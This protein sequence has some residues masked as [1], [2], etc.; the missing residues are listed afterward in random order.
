MKKYFIMIL[1]ALSIA[2]AVAC[3]ACSKGPKYYKLNYDEIDGIT[4]T[5]DIFNDADVKEGY[6][7]TFTV[8]I[9]WKRVALDD[10][11]KPYVVTANGVALTA[12]ENGYYSF[13]ISDNTVI[14][15]EGVY[16]LTS[17]L[18]TFDKGNPRN[19]T[20][21]S[22]DGDVEKGITALAG[23]EITFRVNKSSYYVGDYQVC[24]NTRELDPQADGSYKFTVTETTTVSVK[25]LKQDASFVERADGGSGTPS[26]PFKIER[27]IDLYAIAD[28]ASDS[29]YMG[30]FCT[31]YYEMT[32]D[33]DMGGEQLY[34]IGD[35]TTSEGITS[36]FGGNFNGNGHKV[37]NFYISDSIIEQSGFTSI[38]LPYIGMFGYVGATTNGPARISNLGLENFEIKV[39][40]AN[41]G[42][43]SVV[44]G[45]V[46]YGAGVE[47]TGCSVSGKISIAG[48]TSYF[49]YAGGLAGQLQS[50]YQSDDLRFSSIVRSCSSSV[51]LGVDTGYVYAGGGL[52]G[53]MSSGNE[54]ANAVVVNSY[55]TGHVY[56]VMNA[57]GIVGYAGTHTSVLNCY[58]TG[59][60]EAYSSVS[61][62]GMEEYANSYAGGIAGYINYGS[63]VA[64]SFSSSQVYASATAGQGIRE[65]IA[66]RIDKVGN[67]DVASFDAYLYNCYAVAQSGVTNQLLKVQLNWQESDWDFSGGSYPVINGQD[68]NISYNVTIKSGSTSVKT[69]PVSNAYMTMY[70]WNKTINGIPEFVTVG[71]KRSYGYYFDEDCTKKVPYSFIPTGAITLYAATSDYSEVAGY[72]YIGDTDNK[73]F[74]QLTADGKLLYNKGALNYSSYYTYDGQQVIL[75]DCPAFIVTFCIYD[76]ENRVYIDASS[77]YTARAAVNNAGELTI[78]NMLDTSMVDQFGSQTYYISSAKSNIYTNTNP[79]QLTK[80]ASA[81]SYTANDAYKGGWLFNYSLPVDITFNGVTTAGYGTAVIS[82]T[83]YGETEVR[84]TVGDNGSVQLYYNDVDYGSLA[85]SESDKTLT[86]RLYVPYD[87]GSVVTGVTLCRY[88]NL[89][90]TWVSNSDIKEIYFDGL[91]QYNID[92][93]GGSLAVR[94]SV[95]IN[96]T[97]KLNYSDG[98]FTYNGTEYTATVS[99]AN[100]TIN[101]V[102]FAQRDAWYGLDLVDTDGKIYSFDGRGSLT[103]G[104]KYTIDGVEQSGTYTTSSITTSGNAYSFGGK[105]LYVYNY[106]TTADNEAWFIGATNG[107]TLTVSNI[108]PN[109]AT[110]TY[111]GVSVTFTYNPG[112]KSLTFTYM[113]ATLT[114]Y[115]AHDGSELYD[116]EST[117]YLKYGIDGYKGM[118]VSVANPGNYVILDGF[119]NSN[120]GFGTAVLNGIS[121]NGVF[122]DRL[123]YGVDKYGHLVL[124]DP[125]SDSQRVLVKLIPCSAGTE[126]AFRK[127]GTTV[128]YKLVIPDVFYYVVNTAIYGVNASNNIIQNR[129]YTFDGVDTVYCM[130]STSSSATV[131]ATYTYQ[132]LDQTEKDA[133]DNIYRFKFTDGSGKVYNVTIDY[134]ASPYKLAMEEAV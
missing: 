115:A 4:Y 55:S 72:Y 98:K 99:G 69:I 15:V 133:L 24:A 76:S 128:Y 29:F 104:G 30:R 35:A 109:G 8:E 103:G 3:V 10:E 41:R 53:F 120:Y 116:S 51:E 73:E 96:G 6:V 106:F 16:R 25:G 107:D 129:V 62:A 65:D 68:T 22:D 112:D 28:L 47:I 87:G 34:V 131:I 90:G 80:R 26:D 32:K 102:T 94:G 123:V 84:Y 70:D 1:A 93:S 105:T 63:I 7:V 124:K 110:G 43:V 126:G 89:R 111:K 125:A 11:D 17:Y 45:L 130:S 132:I 71:A 60:V 66:G 58:S 88:D 27:P 37:S 113:D 91:G 42:T 23:E 117:V 122:V 74:I 19:A 54:K 20:Y 2:C 18:V 12:D 38:F 77:Y 78:V 39:N 92:G 82:Y 59:T 46:G 57:G 100:L 31:A 81:I 13:A 97:T 49:T 121:I 40:A 118:Y 79:L 14:R 83:R 21:T 108:G 64:N 61:G 56:G 52:V 36:F 85:Y 86:G 101:G 44:G 134:G 48:D 50:V 119:M 5:S 127:Q 95:T 67:N 9:D 75:Y 114:L 33:I